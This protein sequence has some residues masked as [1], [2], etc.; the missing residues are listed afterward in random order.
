MNAIN[1]LNYS[2][3][4]VDEEGGTI[5]VL[6]QLTPEETIPLYQCLCD[7]NRMYESIYNIPHEQRVEIN[8]G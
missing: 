7:Y 6:G 8:R 3:A 2:V 5:C 1:Q 4:L